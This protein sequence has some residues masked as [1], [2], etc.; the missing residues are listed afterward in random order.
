MEFTKESKPAR[1]K[2]TSLF[3]DDV[4]DGGATVAKTKDYSHLLD[5]DVCLSG[6]HV[7]LDGFSQLDALLGLSNDLQRK[8]EALPLSGQVTTVVNANQQPENYVQIT[9]QAYIATLGTIQRAV[10]DEATRRA[11]ELRCEGPSLKSDKIEVPI[12]TYESNFYLSMNVF[13]NGLLKDLASKN[14]KVISLM[15]S[16]EAARL[17]D[18]VLFNIIALA[19]SY[20]TRI[21]R[22]VTSVTLGHAAAAIDLF[23]VFLASPSLKDSS[24]ALLTTLADQLNIADGQGGRLTDIVDAAQRHFD[25]MFLPKV[26]DKKATLLTVPAASLPT[27]AGSITSP[28]KATVGMSELVFKVKTPTY[29]PS[30]FL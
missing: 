30:D 16:G 6:E 17:A 15:D 27:G 24:R 28:K 9:S 19:A 22:N 8:T 4:I 12:D 14:E 20:S 29:N 21:L 7:D 18:H 23:K 3:D 11:G 26:V 10:K 1:F 2:R 13:L 5:E 25:V